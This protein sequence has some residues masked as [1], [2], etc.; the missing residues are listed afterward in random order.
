M[1]GK[2]VII[3][4]CGFLAALAVLAIVGYYSPDQT[5]QVANSSVMAEISI[6]IPEQCQNLDLILSS[7]CLHKE[8]SKYFNYTVR[9]DLDRSLED[10]KQ[11]GGD[12][13]DYNLLYKKWMKALGFKAEMIQFNLNNET[14]HIVTLAYDHNAYCILDQTVHPSCVVLGGEAQ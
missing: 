1:K 10:I 14:S 4:V 9:D 5:D 7:E 12:C 8:I 3:F 2:G 11:F 13:F 6:P